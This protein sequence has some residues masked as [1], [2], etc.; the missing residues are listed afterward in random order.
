MSAHQTWFGRSTSRS[1]NK[2]GY[3]RSALDVAD[4][5]A[6][7][8]PP[9]APHD[10][11]QPL[12][13]LVVDRM[14]QGL[15][16]QSVIRGTPYNGRGRDSWSIRRI[17]TRFSSRSGAGAESYGA[18]A[19]PADAHG[20]TIANALGSAWIHPRRASTGT[21]RAFFEPLHFHLQPANLLGQR[22]R[23]VV[24]AA[25]AA[26]RTAPNTSD[27]PS[28]NCRFPCAMTV[29]GTPC[30]VLSSLSVRS[31][32]DR[33]HRHPCLELLRMRFPLLPH[34]S[35]PLLGTAVLP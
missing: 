5:S 7:P 32:L 14:A 3:T 8:A 21:L 12:D 29:G 27:T 31:P 9:P 23:Q 20:C 10:P 35:L 6:G 26:R 18:R 1:R 19:N 34:S 33:V 24:L 30:V 2:Y 15:E 17:N 13:P 4:S 28:S 25:H 16:S 22:R 11:H